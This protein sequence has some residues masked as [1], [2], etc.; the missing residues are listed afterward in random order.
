MY[1]FNEVSLKVYGGSREYHEY[2]KCKKTGEVDLITLKVT[3]M[4]I[5]Q[6]PQITT[7]C[8]DLLKLL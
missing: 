2:T 6:E 8:I 7:V 4:V 3:K 5:S 1:T